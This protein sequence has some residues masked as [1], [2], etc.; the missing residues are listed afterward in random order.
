PRRADARPPRLARRGLAVAK[1]AHRPCPRPSLFRAP[2]AVASQPPLP[3]PLAPRARAVLESA[4]AIS[5]HY[6]QKSATGENRAA[7]RFRS[8]RNRPPPGRRA[9]DAIAGPAPDRYLL[10][11]ILVNNCGES[12]QRDARLDPD[13]SEVGHDRIADDAVKAIAPWRANE[14]LVPD[15]AGWRASPGF[16]SVTAIPFP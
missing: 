1:R 10:R 16:G 12:G 15:R 6:A 13:S 5:R 9:P 2:K 14:R 11:Y 4:R 8:P 7:G 3:P